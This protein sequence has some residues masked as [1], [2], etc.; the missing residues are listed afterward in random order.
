MMRLDGCV[1]DQQK[2]QRRPSLVALWPA[3]AKC[4]ELRSMLSF[5]A[6]QS[7]TIGTLSGMACLMS[8]SGIL[9]DLS[10]IAVARFEEQTKAAEHPREWTSKTKLKGPL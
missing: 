2:K 4:A 9:T 7:A 8:E 5:D 1:H 6:S 3:K 10:L